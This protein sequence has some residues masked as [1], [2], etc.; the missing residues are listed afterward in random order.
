VIT[1][2]G[3][4]MEPEVDVFSQRW[5]ASRDRGT[6]IGHFDAYES[7]FTGGIAVAAG[8]W[9]GNPRIVVA[10]GPGR[11]PEV[12]VFDPAGRQLSSFTA[13]ETSYRGGLSVAVGDLDADAKP[14][15]VVGTLAA[16]E[17]IRAFQPDGTPFG[18]VIGPFP[19]DGRG[20]SVG[21]ADLNGTG[22][23]VIVAAE[24]RGAD[25]LLELVDPV[26]GK[27]IRTAHPIPDAEA[28]LRVG[29]G[30]LD[31]DGRDE[32]LVT[33]GWAPSGAAGDI[34]VLGPTL[35]R[36]WLTNV[37]AYAGAGMW[38]AVAPRI[39]LPVR[40]NGVT[41]RL[42]PR[43]RAQVVVGRF[44]DAAGAR[45]TAAGFRATIDWGDGTSWRG[46]VLR[47]GRGNVDV[48]S[49]KRYGSSGVYQITVTLTDSTNRTSV[50]RSTA[51][52]R[53]A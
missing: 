14:E 52:V 28:G 37:Y 21:V 23:G 9:A 40:A 38:V 29:A 4:G 36:K 1:A 22:R 42:R 33:P 24:A 34:R 26:S 32:I 43:E 51:V 12:R 10:P 20:V 50:A 13:F 41:L 15:I 27:V 5:L 31:P 25:P 19:P 7:G 47:R 2:P 17:R 46:V 30:D 16:P 8:Y 48:R 35:Q 49:T 6:R 45:S 18:P 53:R 44:H 11:T 39:G 3:P